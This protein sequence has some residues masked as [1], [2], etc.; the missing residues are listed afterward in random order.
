MR[1]A[2][3]MVGVVL[4]AVVALPL[5]AA[6]GPVTIHVAPS[7]NDAWSGAKPAPAGTDGPLATLAA[8]RDAARKAGAGV[9]RRIVVGA[10]T[11]FLTSPLTLDARDSG[12]TVE[13][14]PGA[15]P[16]LCGG[17]RLT[18]WQPDG[19]RFWAAAVPEAAAGTWDFRVLVVNGR[20]ADRARLPQA[21]RFQ[22]LSEFKVPW[23][24]STGG[25]W[26]RKPTPQELTTLRYRPEDLPPSLDLR[27]AE[28]TV[29]HMWDESLAGVAARD[30]EAHRLTL[31]KPLGHPPGAF[32]VKDYV[33]WNVREGMTQPGQ[34]YLDRTVGKVVYWPR[35]GEEMK[36]AE[37]FAPVV[38]TLIKIAGKSGEPVRNVTL[39]GLGLTV[40]SVPLA[41]GG[42]GAGNYAGAVSL[43][44]TAG[45]RLTGLTVENVGG[46]GI[47]ADGSEGLRVE[48]CV[49][50]HTGACGLI[51]RGP[52]AVVADNLVHDVGLLCPSGIGIFGGGPRTE[53]V[54][55][56][57]HDTSYS[58]VNFSGED[59]R[60][61]S[62]LIYRA[63]KVLHDGAGIYSFKPR[64][65]VMRG[66]F[67]RDIID[68]GGYGASAYYLDEQAE[69]CLVE[70][71]LS[72]GIARPSHNH[73]ARKNTIRNNVFVVEGDATLTFPRSSEYTVEKNVVVAGG[74]ITFTNPDAVTV[75]KDNVLWSK[76][77]KVEGVR[78][79][80][81]AD[82]GAAAL[83]AGSNADPK[84]LDGYERGVCRFAS[85]SPTLKLGIRP[86]DVSG[87]GR[88]P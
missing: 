43:H 45:C 76:A 53:V 52:G 25:G 58:A 7:G 78:L 51:V 3:M 24:S 54:H 87:A 16:V 79:R 80:D 64:R 72:L 85:D 84:L 1:H 55:N 81:Y 17:R 9:P 33:V 38:E 5:G 6:E 56:E 18:D 8:A 23:M 41:P 61:E 32:G 47:R 34:W 40:T 71:N 19:D 26:Q 88:R 28:I 31:S 69:D 49:V 63:M 10:G 20:L 15:A 29:F 74:K 30:A 73:M 65:L 11:Y 50:H 21:G 37:A 60:I 12:L 57:I 83:A 4:G 59:V 75:L 14:A 67:I 62:N 68:T 42:F 86:I 2:A 77:G 39:R 27:N 70:G 66:N 36:R 82:A 44:A 46:Q 22:H 48:R 13:A 35:P